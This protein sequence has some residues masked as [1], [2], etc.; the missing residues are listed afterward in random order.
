MA[1]NVKSARKGFTLIELLVVISI[2]A[3]LIAL[4]LPAINAAR[5]AARNT[6][7]KNNLRQ[8]GISMHTF[9]DSDPNERYASGAWDSARDGCFDT[10]GWGAD[11]VKL[12]AGRP[13]ELRCPTSPLRGI[14]KLNDMLGLS[15]S[16]ASAAYADRQG[17]G[18][19][20]TWVI[21]SSGATSTAR[22]KSF[23]DL[24]RSSGLNTNYANSW[25]AVRGQPF[26]S[27]QG[28]VIYITLDTADANGETY[29]DD[30]K[31][32]HNGTGPLN[33]R[34]ID[35]SDVPSSNIPVIG[36]G[37]PGDSDE[38]LLG[39]TIIDTNGN[40]VDTDLVL[41]A[42][43]AESFNDGPAGWELSSSD[44]VELLEPDNV[45]ANYYPGAS[46]IHATYPSRGV[47][48]V[49]AST[50][51]NGEYFFTGVSGEHLILQDTRD[52]YAWHRGNAN[53]LMADGSVKVLNDLNGDGFFNPGFPADTGE[54]AN[55]GFDDG[56]CEIDAFETFCGVMLS[57]DILEKEKLEN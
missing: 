40:I 10:Y 28:N 15:T 37:A 26:L 38:A 1:K 42:R 57:N 12:G 29:G 52:W 6:Q 2:I 51:T 25:F 20:G 21:S 13:S 34:Q 55:D 54:I 45:G 19:C 8:I 30:L 24:L 17:K 11:M 27:R 9:A 43:L 4:L 32:A 16:N 39:A 3:I 47:V 46:V 7:C 44:A 56:T 36:D 49:P 14:E 31:D 41:G 33:R 5:E 22:T 48:V 23:G 53:L 35:T 18:F 50:A